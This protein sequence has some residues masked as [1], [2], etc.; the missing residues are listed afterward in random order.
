MGG[1]DSRGGWIIGR[2]MRID[3]KEAPILHIGY[4]LIVNPGGIVPAHHR[5]L[6]KV[7]SVVHSNVHEKAGCGIG[8]PEEQECTDD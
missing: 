3:I 2:I 4:G 8:A 5:G 1:P 7:E 6:R